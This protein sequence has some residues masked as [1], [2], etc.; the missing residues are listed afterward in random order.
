M[1]I[2]FAALSAL[3]AGATAILAKCGVRK[4]DS[5]LATALRTG[6][7]LLFA[8]LMV[9][10]TGAQE[11]LSALSLRFQGLPPARRGCAISRRC[12]SAM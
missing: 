4:T 2:L 11:G 1:Y 5:D 9:F 12:P 7:V 6:V 10:V 8:W 3:F